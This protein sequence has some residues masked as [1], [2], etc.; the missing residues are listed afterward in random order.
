MRPTPVPN[1]ILLK[2]DIHTLRKLLPYVWCRD[3]PQMRVRVILAFISL[4]V[5]KGATLLVPL[6][7]KGAVD[8]L[9]P[10]PQGLLTLPVILILSYGVARLFSTLF[11]EIRDG[12]FATGQMRVIL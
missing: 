11:S 3:L 7:F 1:N 8:S 10:L 12:I 6:L 2:P 4:M 9:S 5:A